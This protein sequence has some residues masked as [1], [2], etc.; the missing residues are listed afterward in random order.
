MSQN[1]AGFSYSNYVIRVDIGFKSVKPKV[2]LGHFPLE[3]FLKN[4]RLLKKS[5]SFFNFEQLF[6]S[7]LIFLRNFFKGSYEEQMIYLEKL[8]VCV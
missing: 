5:C 1:G 7:N 2:C 3:K 6:F 8:M 4:I